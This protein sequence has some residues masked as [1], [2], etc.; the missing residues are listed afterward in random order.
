MRQRAVLVHAKGD[1]VHR[2]GARVDAVDERFVRLRLALAQ[3]RGRRLFRSGRPMRRRTRG[4]VRD[5]EGHPRSTSASSPWVSMMHPDAPIP[6]QTK[7][8][9]ARRFWTNELRSTNVDIR[10]PDTRSLREHR[11]R[12]LQTTR[13][14]QRG[15]RLGHTGDAR[16]RLRL[17]QT[18]GVAPRWSG[19][20]AVY[21]SARRPLSGARHAEGAGAPRPRRAGREV[22]AVDRRGVEVA[23]LDA[24]TRSATATSSRPSPGASAGRRARTS[25]GGHR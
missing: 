1:G 12:I 7:N 8:N 13:G 24:A 3:R 19:V 18:G 15:L 25:R 23:V 5:P 9:T 6:R 4:L 11:E 10:P 17:K 2:P 16:E 21:V 14:H 20:E 22:D